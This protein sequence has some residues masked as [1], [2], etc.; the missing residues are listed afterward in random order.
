[1]HF[2]EK[3]NI[4]GF[5]SPYLYFRKIKKPLFSQKLRILIFPKKI[6][7]GRKQKIIFAILKKAFGFKALKRSLAQNAKLFN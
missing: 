4:Q 7:H 5:F 1:M 2:F 6:W 3:S